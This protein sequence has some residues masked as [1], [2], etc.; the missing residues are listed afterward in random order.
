MH[1]FFPVFSHIHTDDDT[2]MV[3]F[4][5]ALAVAD[6]AREEVLFHGVIHECEAASVR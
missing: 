3:K 4:P 6:V 1:N 2:L 5:D